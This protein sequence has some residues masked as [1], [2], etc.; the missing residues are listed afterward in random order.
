MNAAASTRAT[1]VADD[2]EDLG[3]EPLAERRISDVETIK[4]L[5]DPL[6]LRILEVMT[7]GHAETFTVKRLAGILGVS[8]TKLY[9]HVN[10]LVERDLIRPA[11]QRVV[12][13]IIETSYRVGQLQI[14][15]DRSL[16]AG[17]SA[18]LHDV[19]TTVFESARDDIE[20]GLRTGVIR[21]DEGD[22]S[23]RRLIV[24]KG[25]ARLTPEQAVAFRER[26]VELI[27]S[28]ESADVAE[29][30]DG[31][32]PYGLVLGFYPVTDREGEEDE[33]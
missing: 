23:H 27:G 8:Q 10:Q 33:A 32:G 30:A 20:R 14:S 26:L 19:L 6:R 16:L 22:E 24:S 29:P 5:S 9:H 2:T 15:L 1:A 25:L 17:D 31:V 21:V 3:P 11:G 12:S 13:G 4:A 18:G 28:F 7:A